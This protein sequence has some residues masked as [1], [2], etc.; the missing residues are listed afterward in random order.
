[1]GRAVLHPR[2]VERYARKSHARACKCVC[3][4]VWG[5]GGCVCGLCV[6]C[7]LC[8]SLCVCVC[9]CIL[10]VYVG[11]H[12]A[13]R[14]HDVHCRTARRDG[15]VAC[16]GAWGATHVAC[17]RISV[18][19]PR[20]ARLSLAAVPARP[21]KEGRHGHHSDAGA[22]VAVA[23]ATVGARGPPLPR[24]RC[25]TYLF[26][27]W[28]LLA[29]IGYVVSSELDPGAAAFDSWVRALV[30]RATLASVCDDGRGYLS[31]SGCDFV[32]SPS[33]NVAASHVY[34]PGS[35]ASGNS[36]TSCAASRCSCPCRGPSRP[37]G[38]RTAGA[39]TTRVRPHMLQRA[40]KHARARASL[41]V[42][43]LCRARARACV[44][45]RC[46]GCSSS[47]TFTSRSSCLCTARA[48]S[49]S[50]S[51]ARCTT[52]RCVTLRTPTVA[53]RKRRWRCC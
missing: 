16:K 7:V 28:Q 11:K 27:V 36:S 4:C 12:C 31:A 42:Q 52:R 46:H 41:L 32:S 47:A 13:C 50:S 21:R 37:S 15:V 40:R 1:M 9:M 5:G 6:A 48:S 14:S 10:F 49:P 19:T 18:T 35:T 26:L 30:A 34:L 2:S 29:N 22:L 53:T 51:R 8:V 39:R 23:T 3:V 43:T 20:C 44:Q 24:A 38:A 25:H 45:P 33:C 17:E